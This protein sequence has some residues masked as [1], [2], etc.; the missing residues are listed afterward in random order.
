MHGE[1]VMAKKSKP[2]VK[3][4]SI[5]SVEEEMIESVKKETI[6]SGKEEVRVL[7]LSTFLWQLEESY[8]DDNFSWFYYSPICVTYDIIPQSAIFLQ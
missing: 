8:L 4:E 5:S 3:E 2:F 1:K 7:M 6:A